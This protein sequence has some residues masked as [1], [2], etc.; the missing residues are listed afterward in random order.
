MAKMSSRRRAVWGVVLATAIGL[1]TALVARRGIVIDESHRTLAVAVV[2]AAGVLA[3]G[4]FVLFT[5]VKWIVG[6]FWRAPG[7]SAGEV[8]LASSTLA[9]I[10]AAPVL[11][12]YTVS[13][14]CN[15]RTGPVA[16]ADVPHMLLGRRAPVFDYPGGIET[17]INCGG[18]TQTGWAGVGWCVFAIAVVLAVLLLIRHR[19]TRRDLT[20]IGKHVRRR[21]TDTIFFGAGRAAS[22]DDDHESAASSR[23]ES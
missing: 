19:P 2:K 9:V 8:A 6:Q 10:G 20:S 7:I 5:L 23:P 18:F 4:L 13:G 11:R 21:A 17:L 12:D 3:V 1:A 16:L 22:T 14:D 15:V